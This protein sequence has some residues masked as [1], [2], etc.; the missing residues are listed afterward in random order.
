MVAA[1]ATNAAVRPNSTA[2][3]PR[4]LSKIGARKVGFL[5][6]ASWP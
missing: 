2:F 4:S 1:V 3:A 6:I 5:D